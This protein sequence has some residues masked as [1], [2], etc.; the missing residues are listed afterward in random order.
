MSDVVIP[1]SAAIA[2]AMLKRIGELLR[3]HDAANAGK[4]AP[5]FPF[6][7][8]SYFANEAPDGAKPQYAQVAEEHRHFPDVFPLYFGPV[9]PSC[10]GDATRLSAERIADLWNGMPGGHDGFC[11]QWGYQQ[12]ARAVEDEVRANILATPALRIASGEPT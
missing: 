3:E 4:P 1:D 5:A 2:D 11:K 12:F 7:L 9:A 10:A 6:R 8:A